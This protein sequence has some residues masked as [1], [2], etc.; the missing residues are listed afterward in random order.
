M[1]APIHRHSLSPPVACIT[2]L[3]FCVVPIKRKKKKKGRGG[4]KETLLVLSLCA[5]CLSSDVCLS[6]PGSSTLLY[7]MYQSAAVVTSNRVELARGMSR[8]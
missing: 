4:V 2:G 8:G 1:H 3:A 7:S 6:A 5:I